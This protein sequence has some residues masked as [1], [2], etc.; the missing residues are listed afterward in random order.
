MCFKLQSGNKFSQQGT[1]GKEG[2][3][4]TKPEQAHQKA[5]MEDSEEALLNKNDLERL[6]KLHNQ[7]ENKAVGSTPIP[8]SCSAAQS[9]NMYGLFSSKSF[10]SKWPIY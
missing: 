9:S 5:V 3:W 7:F 2:N 10:G 6:N 1:V 8:D 4:L